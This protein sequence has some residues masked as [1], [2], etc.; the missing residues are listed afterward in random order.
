MLW[1]WR[2]RQSHAGLAPYPFATGKGI[3]TTE[4]N[5]REL[6]ALNG[7]IESL[8]P[9]GAPILDVSNERALYY[10]LQRRPPL[11]CADVN[12]LSA[13]PLLAEA[14]AQLEANRPACV[15]VHGYDAVANYDGLSYRT[16][17]PALAAWIDATYPRRV[18][19]GRFTVATR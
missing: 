7:F 9:A 18:Q 17:V 3:Y 2:A 8:A 16:R 19:I 6:A 14:M 11:R 5:S 4:E 12:M 1:G 13:P 10:L 15:I